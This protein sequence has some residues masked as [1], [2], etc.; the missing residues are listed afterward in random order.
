MMLYLIIDDDDHAD[1]EYHLRRDL[2]EALALARKLSDEAKERYGDMDRYD[3]E[4]AG[5]EGWWFAES[6]E[7]RWKV[8][9][10]EVE[11]GA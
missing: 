8:R 5:A 11:L 1:P 6:G 4:C 3:N 7:Q 9:V 2:K 10:R